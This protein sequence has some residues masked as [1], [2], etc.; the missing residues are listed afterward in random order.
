M[1][2]ECAHRS[3][4][5]RAQEASQN[6]ESSYSSLITHHSLLF[7]HHSSWQRE[8][9]KHPALSRRLRQITHRIDESQRCGSVARIELAGDD[10]ARP[11]ADAAEDRDVLLAV[12]SAVGH[13]LSDDSGAAFELPQQLA[14]LRVDCFEPPLH[15]PVERDVAGSDERAAP[16]RKV[17]FDRPYLP[18]VD[19]IPGIELAAM[20]AGTSVHFYTHTNV[21]SAGDV[22]RLHSLFVLAEV[23]MRDVEES[24]Q[25]RVRRRLPV[26]RS[27]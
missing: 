2:D 1:S 10:R 16:H 7:T 11:A 13:R 23:L 26:F 14:R 18:R 15:R 4:V 12:R 3:E 17:F 9:V 27:G 22:V 20:A 21:R 6:H 19:G 24:R 8:R 5:L 25:W